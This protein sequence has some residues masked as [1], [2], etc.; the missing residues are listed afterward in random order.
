MFPGLPGLPRSRCL[1]PMRD[2]L[3]CVW[4]CVCLLRLV[5]DLIFECGGLVWLC[6]GPCWLGVFLIC[7]QLR[8]FGPL[9]P[10][11][12]HVCCILVNFALSFVFGRI[13][14]LVRDVSEWFAMVCFVLAK[15]GATLVGLAQF[16]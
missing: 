9:R 3:A 11:V 8:W 13:L 16:T 14:A 1:C 2:M 4:A 5:F 6:F 15:F 12:G 7:M 10:E